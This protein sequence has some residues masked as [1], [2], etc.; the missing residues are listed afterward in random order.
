[1]ATKSVYSRGVG[2]LPRKSLETSCAAVLAAVSVLP[3][4][5][6]LDQITA[7]APGITA[8]TVGYSLD[9]AA[10]GASAGQEV[11]VAFSETGQATC[12]TTTCVGVETQI[13]SVGTRS[14][15]MFLR[16]FDS[17][18]GVGYLVEVHGDMPLVRA[19]FGVAVEMDETRSQVTGGGFVKDLFGLDVISVAGA[20]LRCS[21]SVVKF[22]QKTIVPEPGHIANDAIEYSDIL[23]SLDAAK[24]R[25]DLDERCTG[26]TFENGPFP[27]FV[28]FTQTQL[29][30]SAVFV[31]N[32]GWSTFVDSARVS[33]VLA[34]KQQ[35]ASSATPE[36]FEFDE[37]LDVGFVGYVPVQADERTE[38]LVACSVRHA[39]KIC[40][41]TPGC[42][43]FS[44]HNTR[45]SDQTTIESGPMK[46]RAG[47]K[48]SQPTTVQLNF[49][50][51][52]K[53]FLKSAVVDVPVGTWYS[54]NMEQD[55]TKWENVIAIGL[56]ASGAVALVV[57]ISFSLR[58]VAKRPR[59]YIRGAD[60]QI[61][62]F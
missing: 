35:E 30:A 43:S 22:E 21:T 31:A 29:E 24:A 46:G 27:R 45:E 47:A 9:A 28:G 25:C 51:A 20:A 36:A 15:Y 3:S 1:M 48:I 41:A 26:F 5:L 2:R 53:S 13:L 17:L 57:I 10:M 56:V 50:H 6:V 52:A 62:A 39:A 23:E 38:T 58:R 44:F 49:K 33:S 59:G 60:N 18:A 4:K 11:G 34:N 55:D 8:W 32:S 37:Q 16:D 7:M 54:Y 19:G 14:S 40:R 42:L 12:Y 61:F